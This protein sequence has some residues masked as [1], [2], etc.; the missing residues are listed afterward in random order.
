MG[1]EPWLFSAV[2][3]LQAAY[4]LLWLVPFTPRSKAE[5]KCVNTRKKRRGGTEEGKGEA[6]IECRPK[7]TAVGW[8]ASFY[9]E[10]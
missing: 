3:R 4:P 7:K 6:P 8:M 9:K 5:G 10:A 1:E 2:P